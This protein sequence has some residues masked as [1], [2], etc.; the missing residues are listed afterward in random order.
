MTS[1]AVTDE[2]L[3]LIYSQQHE[4]WLY[5]QI[6]ETKRRLTRYAVI[7]VPGCRVG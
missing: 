2:N 5:D 7:P 1:N 6:A 4:S 3:R